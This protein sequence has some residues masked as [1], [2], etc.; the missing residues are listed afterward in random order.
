MALDELQADDE[1]KDFNGIRYIVN[2]DLFNQVEPINVDFIE[3][4]KGSGFT[5]SSNLS[6]EASC[7]G[8]CS[9]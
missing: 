6:K 8:S 2:K 9:C 1:V 4:E 3:N 5:I 7:G